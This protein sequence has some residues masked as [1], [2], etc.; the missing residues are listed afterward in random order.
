MGHVLLVFVLYLCCGKCFDA[1]AFG[2]L[3][4]W[5]SCS[6]CDLLSSCGVS[7]AHFMIGDVALVALLSVCFEIR[8]VAVVHVPLV[9][10]FSIVFW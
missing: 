3:L 4:W 10:R 9:L 8:N 1:L 2:M 7:P 6:F 5:T